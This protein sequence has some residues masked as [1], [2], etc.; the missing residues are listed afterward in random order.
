M[1]HTLAENLLRFGVKNLSEA[2]IKT[3]QEQNPNAAAPA[4]ATKPGAT[5]PAGTTTPGAK[6]AAQNQRFEATVNTRNSNNDVPGSVV[7][8]AMKQPDG[9]FLP[10][11][12][13]VRYPGGASVVSFSL[14]NSNG[15]YILDPRGVFKKPGDLRKL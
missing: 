4:G 2:N 9:S 6:P 15:V 5:A 1:K 8:F 12:I 11:N 7:G 13:I 14:I 3:L 10:G